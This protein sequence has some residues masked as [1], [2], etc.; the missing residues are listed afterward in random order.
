MNIAVQAVT[1][2]LVG[3]LLLAVLWPSPR[4]GRNLLRRWLTEEPSA[5]QVG[6]AVRYL[7][8]RRLWYPVLFV[9]LSLVASPLLP[10]DSD[11][12]GS[13]VAG[14]LWPLLCGMLLAELA[15]LRPRRDVLRAAS[16]RKR[17]LTDLVPG[18]A[19]V[20]FGLFTIVTVFLGVLG[21]VYREPV[22]ALLRE[23][24]SQ[25]D[26]YVAVLM[27][28]QSPRPAFAT[29]FAIACAVIVPAIAWT[30]MARPTRDDPD[31]DT[32]L[33]RRSARVAFG[34]G[35]AVQAVLLQIVC[36]PLDNPLTVLKGMLSLLP[37]PVQYAHSLS[38]IFNRVAP[39]VGLLGWICSVFPHRPRARTRSAVG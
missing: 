3:L 34:L 12:G 13:A 26:A 21:V 23:H 31:V 33:R 14:Y 39:V 25:V 17:T 6:V 9:A 24:S 4:S 22:Q 32:A 16:L 8:R 1:T 2:M 19:L 7:K 10:A 27:L 28:E 18:W 15:D 37:G 5:E 30:A 20:V 35:I 11:R 36:A 38:F 29:G